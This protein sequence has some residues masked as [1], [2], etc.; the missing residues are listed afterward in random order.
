MM[1]RKWYKEW[2]ANNLVWHLDEKYEEYL[3]KGER[4]S[5]IWKQ[6]PEANPE[7]N[8]DV[9]HMMKSTSG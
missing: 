2:G 5:S 8:F 6:L 9:V 3:D 4:S 1:V 7:N